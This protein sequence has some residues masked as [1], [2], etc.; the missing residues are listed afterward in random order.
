MRRKK[1][2]K[3]LLVCSSGGHLLQLARLSRSLDCDS[4]FIW[5]TFNKPDANSILKNE[6]KYWGYFPTNRN[7]YNLLSLV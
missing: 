1:I 7:I 4:S 2:K 3:I 5:V 6:K